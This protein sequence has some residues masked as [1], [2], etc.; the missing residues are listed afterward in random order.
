MLICTNALWFSWLSA[1]CCAQFRTLFLASVIL[2]HSHME[3]RAN[4]I[5]SCFPLGRWSVLWINSAMGAESNKWGSVPLTQLGIFADVGHR[6]SGQLRASLHLP[7]DSYVLYYTTIISPVGWNIYW[8][9]AIS[10][11]KKKMVCFRTDKAGMWECW[12]LNLAEGGRVL[13]TFPM[14]GNLL[15]LSV[16]PSAYCKVSFLDP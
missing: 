7:L 8:Q 5:K 16:S 1:G 2:N 11:T 12:N 14:E 9:S 6:I 3:D 10:V 13:L 4:S 15:V